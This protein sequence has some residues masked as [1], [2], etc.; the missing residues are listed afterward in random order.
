[1][2]LLL[3]PCANSTNHTN[4]TRAHLHLYNKYTKRFASSSH[5][6]THTHT[7]IFQPFQQNTR[8]RYGWN[9]QWLLA[10]ASLFFLVSHIFISHFPIECQ[11]KHRLSRLSEMAKISK[12]WISRLGSSVHIVCVRGFVCRIFNPCIYLFVFSQFDFLYHFY[13]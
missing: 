10:P 5:D 2:L 12:N 1:M 8:H 9:S 13:K 11:K 3:M 6:Y 7:H 4:S